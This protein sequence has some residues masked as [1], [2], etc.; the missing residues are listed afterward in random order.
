MIEASGSLGPFYGT[1]DPVNGT[2]EVQTL[3]L[4]NVTGGTFQILFEGILTSAITW[5]ATTNTLLA[6][7]QAALDAHPS[8]G[9]NGCVASNSSL[10]SGNGD[11]LLTY[12]SNRGRQAVP[13]ASVPTLAN[14]TGSG[15]A[16][17]IAE[18]TPGVDSTVRG[19]AV[20]ATYVNS[21]TGDSFTNIGTALAPT[22]APAGGER[23]V[24]LSSA[25]ILAL[26]AT[27][28]ELIPAPGANRIIL[29]ESILLEI[30][31]TSTAYANGGV[32]EIR[33]ENASGALV[34]ATFPANFVTGGAGT[35]YA[36]NI[37]LATILTPAANKA[38][39]MDNA[40]AAF[41][42]G[43]GTMRA[44]IK[45]RIVSVA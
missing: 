16:A 19:A 25:D 10:S 41:I 31:R 18:T 34:S 38:L 11:V 3:T 39:V 30:V 13:T 6:N 9:T 15:K 32:L 2:D 35:A 40:T 4:A 14:L 24:S 12:G 22:W 36:H 23:T 17:S 43:T 8:L 42:T 20:G 45:Y 28:K 5:S 21:A 37:G 7:I 27:P 44:F 1:T 33:Y 29:L 26:N